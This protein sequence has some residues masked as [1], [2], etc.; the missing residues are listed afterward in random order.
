[1]Y[2]PFAIASTVL[3]GAALTVGA[4][5]AYAQQKSMKDLIKGAWTALSR[6]ARPSPGR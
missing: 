2:R 3:F 5:S 4:G 1:M 6:S